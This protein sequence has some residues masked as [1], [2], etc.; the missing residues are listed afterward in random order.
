MT[1]PVTLIA[2][3]LGSGKTTL[4]R[5]ILS[6]SHGLRC[7]VVV[8]EFGALGIDGD[9]IVRRAAT[10]SSVV[11]LSNGCICC[12]IQEDLRATLTALVARSRRGRGPGRWLRRSSGGFDRI[13]IEASGTASPGPAVQTFLLDAD[14][15]ESVR[16]DGVVTLAHAAHIEDQ[17]ATTAE[18]ADQIAYADRI[19][20]NH[21]DRVGTAELEHVVALVQASN[22]L[23]RVRTAEQAAVPLEWVLDAASGGGEARRL[24]AVDSAAATAHT[25]GLTSISL[26]ATGAIDRAALLIWLEFLAKRR[27]QELMRA[28]GILRVQ[29]SAG[30]LIVQGVYQWLE[31]VDDPAPAP[32]VSRLVLIGR[33]LDREEILRGWKAIGGEAAPVG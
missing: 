17:L 30:S 12:E 13:L 7:A 23:A 11:E 14:L 31:A 20:I 6:E 25:P 1:I 8:N 16:L 22:P 33:D 18:A 21:A 10:D 15:A 5:R 2:G 32:D 9:L 29:G 28:K 26:T 19:I 24:D 4:V 3:F 27:G